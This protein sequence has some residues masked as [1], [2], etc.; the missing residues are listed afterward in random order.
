MIKDKVSITGMTCASCS[1]TVESTL[2]KLEGV[3]ASVNFA[4]E[5]LNFE[6]LD[7]SKYTYSDIANKIDDLGYGIEKEEK[8]ERAKSTINERYEAK[9]NDK[10][11]A[12][13]SNF[14]SLIYA[15]IFTIPLLYMSMGDML[16][17]YIPYYFSPKIFPSNFALL[18]LIFTIP[19]FIIGRNFYKVGFR[20]LYKLHPNMDSL[21]AIGTFVAFVYS[22]VAVFIIGWGYSGYVYKLYFESAAVIITLI[23]LGKYLENRA[24][25]KTSSSIE[26]LMNLVPEEA[27][28]FRGGSLQMIPV[29][30]VI[31]GDLIVV[32]PGEKIAVD[33]IITKG[34]TSIDE[35]MITG[36]PL[37]IDKT[38]G[39]KVIGGSINMNG[40][41]Q[42]TADKVGEDTMLYKIVKLV[43]DA[44]G[45][46]APIARVADVVSLYFVPIVIAISILSGLVWFV[47]GSDIS[48]VLSIIISVLIIACP[49]ALGLATPTAIMVGTGKAATLG[50]LIKGGESLE[51][52]HKSKVVVLDKTGTITE[53]KPIVD[54]VYG[55][56]EKEILS[57]AAS[58]ETNSEHP[59][60]KAIVEKAHS[61]N[62]KLS[63]VTDF[64]NT[65]GIGIKCKIKE[66]EIVVGNHRILEG[67]E[68]SV[69]FDDKLKEIV[70]K[71][72]TPV[73]I[74]KN[75]NVI[76]LISI[77]D[78]IKEDS[79]KAI[80]QLKKIGVK[81]IMLT[82]DN[83]K[84]AQYIADELEIEQVIAEVLPTEKDKVIKDLQSD[85]EKVIFVGDGINDAPALARADVGIAI[86]S[87]TDIAIESA[88]FVLM[89]SS[90]LDVVKAIK[91]SKMTIRNIKQN[92]VWAFIYN[93]VGIPFAAGIVYA[94]GGP[95][96]NPMIAGLAMSLSSVS[97]V[98]NALRLRFVK[99]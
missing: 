46:K 98:V 38:I 80:S 99:V 39:A 94:F 11:R 1:V 42:I 91:L 84:S 22:L 74:K 30:E 86:G 67:V 66:D 64:I 78:K 53:G 26:K 23:L 8:T 58:V 89:N 81:V 45:K 60:A 57:I 63:E 75:N 41:I 10:E 25:T 18:Q 43:G 90:V 47:L 21:V 71:G 36:E 33:S 15:S 29:S 9:K 3:K 88:D 73:W 28:V 49:C 72:K 17:L 48:F 79:K 59:L 5:T 24:K 85:G 96:L 31:V 19:V 20:A 27:R 34:N 37:P 95:L 4:T 14:I 44:Q 55:D 62:L 68:Q 93:I 12:L 13:K 56:D 40:A 6:I 69:F 7:G 82:G 16:G 54:N 77:A 92:L 83:K 2:N 61:I 50:I 70:S 35:S 97:V 51:I 52:A 76:G 32:K 65:P 87:G